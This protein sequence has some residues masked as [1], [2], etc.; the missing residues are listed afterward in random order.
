MAPV[1]FTDPDGRSHRVSKCDG[2]R[3]KKIDCGMAAR[4]ALRAGRLGA[5]C[6]LISL[7]QSFGIEGSGLGFGFALLLLSDVVVGY[8]MLELL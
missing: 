4:L 1:C 5:G 7:K 6:A 3:Q 8:L 2:G